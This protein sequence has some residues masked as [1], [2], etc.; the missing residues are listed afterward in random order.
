MNYREFVGK[1]RHLNYFKAEM[2]HALSG[3]GRTLQ[4]QL[5]AWQRQ[6]KVHKLRRGI[7]TLNDDDRRAPLSP[8]LISNVLYAP[9]YVSLESALSFFGLIPERV[10]QTT[11][12]TT[13]KTA[14]FQN[15]Y[16][17]FFYRSFKETFFFG[18]ELTKIEEGFSV[19]MATPEKAILDKIYFDPQ[20]RPE[21]DYFLDNLRLQNYETLRRRRLMDFA[22][23]FGSKKVRR[24]AV[25]LAA[26]IRREME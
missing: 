26:L 8:F 21:E 19:F 13:R 6:G 7:Y 11:A 18:Y 17:A 4:N 24:G 25:L 1:T 5:A 15:H 12:V 10:V 22:G 2:L 3:G 9:S 14:V 20:F 16:G 23:R